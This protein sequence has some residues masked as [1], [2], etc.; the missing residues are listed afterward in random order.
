[1]FGTEMK[2]LFGA[3]EQMLSDQLEDRISDALN[4]IESLQ[5]KV[6][7][8]RR[9]KVAIS[10]VLKEMQKPPKPFKPVYTKRQLAMFRKAGR[11]VGSGLMPAR[12]A[13]G[14]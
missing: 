6:T 4:E 3:L 13:V 12:A 7:R 11:Q 5:R 10:K 9:Q 8:L 2:P 1:M 14:M